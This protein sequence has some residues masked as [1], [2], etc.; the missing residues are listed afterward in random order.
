MR[1]LYPNTAKLIQRAVEDE[2]DKLEYDGSVMF[3]EYPDKT[4]L[5]RIIDRIYENERYG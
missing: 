1:H 3:D 5:D 4:S 2:C